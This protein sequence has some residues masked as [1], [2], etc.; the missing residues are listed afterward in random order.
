MKTWIY[1]GEAMLLVDMPREALISRT[2]M[3][4]EQVLR[5]EAEIEFLFNR[6]FKPVVGE[7]TEA[8]A[9]ARHLETVK[10]EREKLKDLERML[11]ALSDELARRNKAPR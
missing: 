9:E 8:E 6:Y 5:T 10:V 4:H 3:L 2:K 7:E 1:R 11:D